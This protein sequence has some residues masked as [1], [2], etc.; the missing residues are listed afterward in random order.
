MKSSKYYRIISF[1]ILF[2]LLFCLGC[3]LLFFP[4]YSL[5]KVE[6][7]E[8]RP[9]RTG[10][11]YILKHKGREASIILFDNGNMKGTRNSSGGLY[12]YYQDTTKLKVLNKRDETFPIGWGKYR[13]ND[14]KIVIE[15][16]WMKDA[17]YKVIKYEGRIIN[18]TTI[19]VEGYFSGPESIFHFYPLEYKPDSTSRY[20]N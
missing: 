3:H 1:C 4:K 19:M 20:V 9:L 16:I 14:N 18:D 12:S 10:G 15:H 6:I 13:T 17:S 5:D 11:V 2:L 8:D 7:S